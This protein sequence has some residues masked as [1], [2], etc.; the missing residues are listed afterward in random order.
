MPLSREGNSKHAKRCTEEGDGSAQA[1]C[2]VSTAFI[3]QN[4]RFGAGAGFPALLPSSPPAPLQINFVIAGAVIHPS[5]ARS[6]SAG[7]L[8]PLCLC[9]IGRS[10]MAALAALPRCCSATGMGPGDE[11]DNARL[12]VGCRVL[13]AC[14]RGKAAPLHWSAS[15]YTR[16]IRTQLRL[17]MFMKGNSYCASQERTGRG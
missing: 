14:G 17:L 7:S 10:P 2:G 5:Q 15:L 8:F 12:P 1:T 9:F 11:R 6:Y 16:A 13:D 3:R 4:Q